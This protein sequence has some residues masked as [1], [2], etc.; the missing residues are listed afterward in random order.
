MKKCSAP[1]V[2]RE[3]QIKTRVSYHFAFVGVALIYFLKTPVSED[4]KW[5]S[6]YRQ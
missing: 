2:I 4:A 1:L 3:M 5:G 6:H